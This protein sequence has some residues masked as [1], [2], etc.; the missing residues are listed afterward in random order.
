MYLCIYIYVCIYVYTYIYIYMYSPHQQ[1]AGRASTQFTAQDLESELQDLGGAS[2]V[3]DRTAK[4]RKDPT[5]V[6]LE[7]GRLD[8]MGSLELRLELPKLLKQEAQIKDV[9]KEVSESPP[10]L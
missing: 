8:F 4:D 9:S 7:S 1:M 10:C 3:P 2:Q 5:A 6:E